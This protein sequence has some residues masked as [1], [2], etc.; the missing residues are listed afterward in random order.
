MG[1]CR[2]IR[3]VGIGRQTYQHLTTSQTLSPTSTR[4]CCARPLATDVVRKCLT[5][6][7]PRDYGAAMS[8]E[9]VDSYQRRVLGLQLRIWLI[10][11]VAFIVGFAIT[12][13]L[14]AVVM[15]SRLD[16]GWN[17]WPSVLGL[18]T[19]AGILA[20]ATGTVVLA[21]KTSD[22][23]SATEQMATAALQEAEITVRSVELQREELEAVKTQAKL[24]EEQL[25]LAREQFEAA[26]SAD[27]AKLQVDAGFARPTEIMGGVKYMSGREPAYDIEVWG[28]SWAGYSGGKIP[29]VL[30]P[31]GQFGFTI[32]SDEALGPL[33]E[34][35][36]ARWPFPDVREL[37]ALVE[38]ESWVG[39]TWR[40]HDDYRGHQINHVPPGQP[41]EYQSP[42]LEPGS[43]P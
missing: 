7:V 19:L 29:A 16:W 3:Q 36:M 39:V 35:A 9:T 5:L 41:R 27:R 33:S 12:A 22:L 1:G 31:Q 10:A 6:P 38:N 15:R 8:D 11:V 37:P 14:L 24:T 18:A 4:L 30:T 28:R 2:Q 34:E 42:V 21:W 40:T 20:T 17:G 26:R 23:A 43:P 13:V 32:S 25:R